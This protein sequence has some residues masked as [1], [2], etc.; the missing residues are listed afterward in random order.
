MADDRKSITLAEI[1]DRFAAWHREQFPDL[2]PEIAWA[3]LEAELAELRVALLGFQ[4]RRGYSAERAALDEGADVLFTLIGVL[5]F[6]PLVGQFPTCAGGRLEE[7]LDRE[8]SGAAS[9]T[10]ADG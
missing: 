1:V 7:V 10:R 8:Y 9:R 4:W 5:R 6:L 2:T 3:K